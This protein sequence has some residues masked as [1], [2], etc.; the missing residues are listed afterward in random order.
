MVNFEDNWW[1]FFVPECFF[2]TVLVKKLLQTKKRLMHRKGCSNVANDLNSDRLKN[3]FAVAI[4]DNDKKELDYLKGCELKYD[5]NK[6]RLLKH[7]TENHFLIQL[8]PPL[9]KW[10]I[11]VL[12]ENNLR[13]E[14]FGY[15]RD[16]K[17]LK[18]KIKS[19]IDNENDL[20]LNNLVGAIIKTDCEAIKK[21]KYF[22]F[23]L[24]EKNYQADIKE[25]ING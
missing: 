10:I 5:S 4:I 11:E 15:P 13:I 18:Q 24:K 6:L 3:L 9:E 12:E 19:D 23:Y 14:D 7:R 20:K 22:L 1:Q 16:Y 21:L 2:D 17:K 8:N 25:L